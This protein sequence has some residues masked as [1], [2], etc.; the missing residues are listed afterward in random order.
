MGISAVLLY[1]IYL[2][3][4]LTPVFLSWQETRAW[5][6]IQMEAEG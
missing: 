3:L 6:K 4:G 5:N 1:L 2:A